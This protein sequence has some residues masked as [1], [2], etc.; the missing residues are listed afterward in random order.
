MFASRSLAGGHEKKEEQRRASGS[1]TVG[2]QGGRVDFGTGTDLDKRTDAQIII[3][4]FK[5]VAGGCGAF[6]TCRSSIELIVD[7]F[8]SPYFAP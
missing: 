4:S 7:T 1:S 2:Y 6:T 8:Q 3:I 5:L